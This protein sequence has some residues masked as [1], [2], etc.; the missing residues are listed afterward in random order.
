MDN[1]QYSSYLDGISYVLDKF[2][3]IVADEAI[4]KFNEAIDKGCA[5]RHE[6]NDDGW[7]GFYRYFGEQRAYEETMILFRKFIDDLKKQREN[8][9]K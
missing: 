1:E 3:T 9:Y 7:H 6:H 8:G 4:K 2:E 5:A